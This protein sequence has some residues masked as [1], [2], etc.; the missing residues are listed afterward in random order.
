MVVFILDTKRL[1]LPDMSNPSGRK[2]EDRGHSP[3]QASSIE[4]RQLRFGKTAW[5]LA[6]TALMVVLGVTV[7]ASS[8]KHNA[9]PTPPSTNS[10]QQNYQRRDF[11]ARQEGTRDHS[12]LPVDT[13][14]EPHPN[15]HLDRRR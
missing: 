2:I 9:A 7:S 14:S 10:A 12:G 13:A 4:K 6:F 8:N 5:A 11:V 3:S 1:S 15:L